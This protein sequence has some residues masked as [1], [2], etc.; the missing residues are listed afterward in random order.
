MPDL[1]Y[2]N[3]LEIYKDDFFYLAGY[4]QI[5][6]NEIERSISSGQ[7]IDIIDEMEFE[8]S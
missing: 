2:K 1:N 5:G 7:I 8:H 4:P 3:G 6:L